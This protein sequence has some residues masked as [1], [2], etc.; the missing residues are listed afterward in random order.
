M[1]IGTDVSFWQDDPTTPRGIDFQRMKQAGAKFTIIRAGQQLWVDNEF[2]ISWA[3]AKQAGLYRGSYWF[4]DSRA[5]P[6]R[7]AELWVDILGYDTGELPL[8][9]DF[10]DRYGGQFHGWKYWYD[11]MERLKE[12][13]PHKQLG[14]YT[15]YYYWQEFASGVKYFAQYPLWVARYNATEPLVPSIWDKWVLWQYTD[16]GDGEKYGVESGNIDL[17]YFNGTEEEFVE[18]FKLKPLSNKT[19]TANFGGKLV[20]YKEK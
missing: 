5:H 17:N 13:L 14:V 20:E 11:F 1:I 19:I 4:Y 15:A 8:W 3:N 9:C 18:Y 10:E 7:Q 16:N 6:K 12:L 2:K